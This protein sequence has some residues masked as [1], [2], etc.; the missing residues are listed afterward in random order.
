MPPRKRKAVPSAQR[1]S[2]QVSSKASRL[3]ENEKN[4][5]SEGRLSR[6]RNTTTSINENLKVV[7][8]M[9]NFDHIPAPPLKRRTKSRGQDRSGNDQ[10]EDME[11]LK[12]SEIKRRKQAIACLLRDTDLTSSCSTT[13]LAARITQKLVRRI[14]LE[15]LLKLHCRKESIADDLKR[16]IFDVSFEKETEIDKKNSIQLSEQTGKQI[17]QGYIKS[18]TSSHSYTRNLSCSHCGSTVASSRYAAHLEKCLGKGGRLSSR[19]ASLRLRNSAC[20]VDQ[21]ASEDNL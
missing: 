19:A 14:S 8:N 7:E 12:E 10:E 11:K 9:E 16:L 3:V 13:F 15:G 20:E 4:S 1:K 17:N 5:T 21:N 2:S 18:G 6:D